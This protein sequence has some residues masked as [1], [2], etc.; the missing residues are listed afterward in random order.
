[1]K[2]D[3]IYFWLTAVVHNATVNVRVY[4]EIRSAP[5][6]RGNSYHLSSKRMGALIGNIIANLGLNINIIL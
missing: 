5:F 3:T 1:M 4:T 2:A 6:N